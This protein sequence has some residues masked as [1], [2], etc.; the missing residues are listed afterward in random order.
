MNRFHREDVWGGGGNVTNKTPKNTAWIVFRERG[1]MAECDIR[2]DFDTNEYPNIFVSRKWHERTSEYICV[3][4]FDT[5]EY[6]NIFV[7]KFWYERISE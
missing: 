4:F 6:P 1:C 3:K 5:N 7:S 2:M